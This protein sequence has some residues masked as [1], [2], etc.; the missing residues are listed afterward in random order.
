[1]KDITNYMI[2][3]LNKQMFGLE[4]PGCGMQ[5]SLVMVSKG[6]YQ[7]AFYMYPAI[8][9]LILLFLFIGISFFFKFKHSYKI[10]IGLI[11]INAVIIAVSYIIKILT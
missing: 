9:T 3:C 10:K 11:I 1:M 5:R 8:F 7:Y 4:C 6:Q 2:P